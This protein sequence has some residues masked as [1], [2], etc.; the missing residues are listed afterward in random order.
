MAQKEKVFKIVINGLDQVVTA[1]EALDLLLKEQRRLSKELQ[2]LPSDSEG[3]KVLE[4]S[5]MSVQNQI[6]D[7]S[8]TVDAGAKSFDNLNESLSET[9]TETKAV[10]NSM[11]FLEEELA[12][13]DA[14]SKELD[15]GSQ[16]F[17]ETRNQVE[18]LKKQIQALELA[19]EAAALGF[20]GLGKAGN[21]VEGLS[22]QV[23]YLNA[24]LSTIKDPLEKAEV[25]RQIEAIKIAIIET[26]AEAKKGIFPEGSLGRLEAEMESLALKIKNVPAG[27]VEYAK[28]QKELDV[29][30]AKTEF[31]SL[32]A[33]EQRQIFKDLGSGITSAFV[34]GAGLIA[35]FAGESED[36]NKAMLILQQSLAAVEFLNQIGETARQAREAKKVAGLALETTLQSGSNAALAANVGLQEKSAVATNLAGKSAKGAGGAFQLLNAIIAANP[37]GVIVTAIAAVAAGVFLLSSK[38]KFFGDIVNGVTDAFG[39]VVQ[40]GKDLVNNF[41]NVVNAITD[42]AG[43]IQNLIPGVAIL[44]EGFNKFF[45]T[46]FNTKGIAESFND[47]KNGAEKAAKAAADSFE[48]GEDKA[49]RLRELSR[50]EILNNATDINA[51]L[52]EAALGSSRSTSDARRSIRVRELKED[53]ANA[54]E[55]LKLENDLTA[56]EIAI[57]ESGNAQKIESLQKVLNGR[58]EGNKELLEQIGKITENEKAQTEERQAAFQEYIQDRIKAVSDALAFELAKLGELNDFEKQ[59]VALAKDIN[60]QIAT[61]DLQFQAGEFKTFQEYQQLKDTVIQNGLNQRK[62]IA[63]EEAEFNL[64]IRNQDRDAEISAIEDRLNTRRSLNETTFGEE[65]ATLERLVKLRQQK[66]TDEVATKGLDPAI[67]EQATRLKEIDEERA[68]INRDLNNILATRQTDFIQQ[69]AESAVKSLDF[70]GQTIQLEKER[71]DLQG[72]VDTSGYDKQ[73]EAINR[74][75]SESINLNKKAQSYKDEQALITNEYDKQIKKLQENYD[76]QLALIQLEKQK[77]AVDEE[78]NQKLL[79]GTLIGQKKFDEAQKQIEL[80]KKQL[81]NQEIKLK[82]ELEVETD[83]SKQQLDKGIKDISDK[84]LADFNKYM[85][86]PIK[87]ELGNLFSELF[88]DNN[89]AIILENLYKLGGEAMNLVNGIFDNLSAGIDIKLTEIAERQTQLDEQLAVTNEELTLT[90]ERLSNLRTALVEARDADKAAITTQIDQQINKE[91]ELK[92]TVVNV[93]DAKKNAARETIALEQQKQDMIVKQAIL[94]KSIAVATAVIQTALAISNT[95]ATVPKVD[96]GV[97]TAILVGLYA[98]TGAAQVATILATPLPTAKDGGLIGEDGQLTPSNKMAKGGYVRG[99]SH[100]Q[101][102]IRGTGRFNNIEVEGGEAVISNRVV[103]QHPS[104]VNSLV[105]MGSNPHITLPKTKFADGGFIPNASDIKADSNDLLRAINNIDLRPTVAITDI[106]EGQKRVATIERSSKL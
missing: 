103:R 61:I 5:L 88:G 89:G 51:Q 37:I 22:V 9:D 78:A 68:Q 31:L 28:L 92:N 26:E 13:L 45:G 10:V 40:V 64:S 100:S 34:G 3:Y 47:I 53:R 18:G 76:T 52:E 35:S 85:A 80:R 99:R 36:A 67:P 106:N 41:G 23:Q 71:K 29:T 96:F 54:L 74:V 62:Q 98:A 8:G 17:K 90:E 32:S 2:N 79:D 7:L 77:I 97:S 101:G 33:V 15:I 50:K 38:F 43:S 25:E 95:I 20:V 48:K 94:G 93:E 1:R 104:L 39:G 14:E 63:K 70:L 6:L 87:A 16:E 105:S 11:N 72:Q 27:S 81:E 24:S 69:E 84:A 56:A 19:S 83:K 73:L 102:G 30:R 21:S 42:I 82:V 12:R 66:L 75:Q 46:K 65:K 4:Q 59:R 55:R 44:K 49:A 57:I 86:D 91:K 58:S 60:A